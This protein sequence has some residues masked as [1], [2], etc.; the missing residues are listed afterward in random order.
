MIITAY[1]TYT[2]QI[3]EEYAHLPTPQFLLGRRAFLEGYAAKVEKVGLFRKL[4]ENNALAVQNMRMEM[5]VLDR[6]IEKMGGMQVG[7]TKFQ[8]QVEATVNSF[9]GFR[10]PVFFLPQDMLI[11]S[12]LVGLL[13]VAF[14]NRAELVE[15]AGIL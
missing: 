10:T 13:A 1:L 8:T 3:R 2:K 6:E 7:Y 4:R 9:L 15:S 14:W 5:E 11:F 12:V